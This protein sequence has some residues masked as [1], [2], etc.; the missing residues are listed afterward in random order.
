MFDL[1]AG[2]VISVLII[3]CTTLLGFIVH[4]EAYKETHTT[5]ISWSIPK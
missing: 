1:V 4:E 3:C 2:I 5:K